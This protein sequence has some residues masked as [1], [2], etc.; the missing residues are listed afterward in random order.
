VPVAGTPR[1]SAWSRRRP[2][3]A[4]S[5][6][7]AAAPCSPCSRRRARRPAR[8][9][10]GFTVADIEATAA[11]LRARGVELLEGGIVDVTGHYPSS[12][13]TGERAIWFH[14]SEGNLLGAGQLVYD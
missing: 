11:E 10:L 8:T 3:R 6:T 7:S 12:G 5:A 1:N 13:A 4:A 14:D 2:A 9:Q